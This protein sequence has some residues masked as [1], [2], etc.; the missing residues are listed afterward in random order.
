[1]WQLFFK[2]FK[3]ILISRICTVLPGCNDIYL[4]LTT[5]TDLK[6][7]RIH[8]SNIWIAISFLKQM[9]NKNGFFLKVGI[10]W[11]QSQTEYPV[12]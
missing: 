12:L 5:G 6:H 8:I 3:Y 4:L 1:M 7:L 10:K 2:T 11:S 9:S